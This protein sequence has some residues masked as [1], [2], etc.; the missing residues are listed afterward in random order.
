MRGIAGG[1]VSAYNAYNTYKQRRGNRD[2]GGNKSLSTSA[3]LTTQYDAR[4][5]YR[6]KRM[7]RRKRRAWVRFTRKVKAVTNLLANQ[8]LSYTSTANQSPSAGSQAFG[9]ALLYGVNGVTP[10]HGNDD[11]FKIYPDLGFAAIEQFKLHFKSA[12]L[13]AEWS[14]PTTNTS[15]VTLDIYEVMC[16]KDIA[17][18]TANN[19]SD[20]FFE[21]I[22]ALSPTPGSGFVLSATQVG[23]TPFMSKL[24]CQ[25]VKI[26]SKTRVLM[27][28]GQ[29][30]HREVRDPKNR[31]IQW[32]DQMNHIMSKAGWTRGFFWVAEAVT[33][34]SLF[35]PAF[36]INYA[37]CRN[38][39]VQYDSPSI[40]AGGRD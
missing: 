4:R 5:L 31:T 38:Y 40:S 8:Y 15:S 6:Y 35:S 33:D 39:S 25:N 11:L 9:Y 7:P 36:R 26:L 14:T 19:L 34:G 23:V 10:G 28:P 21:G 12:T 1:A 3:P 20:L 2:N 13:D 24:F 18:S 37:N 32:T 29:T 30:C 17:A 22:A 16:R 27:S